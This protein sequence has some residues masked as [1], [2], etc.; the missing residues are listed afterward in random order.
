MTSGGAV[1]LFY[2]DFFGKLK[3][4]Y[5]GGTGYMNN[6]NFFFDTGGVRVARD[7][8]AGRLVPQRPYSG[9]RFAGGVKPFF[10]RRFNNVA[11]MF[12]VFMRFFAGHDACFRGGASARRKNFFIKG[13]LTGILKRR[14]TAYLFP[15]SS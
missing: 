15:V 8:D 10:Q 11:D 7:L 6:Q 4:L 14:M 9:N 13:S 1:Y 5:P 2:D 3:L 12:K